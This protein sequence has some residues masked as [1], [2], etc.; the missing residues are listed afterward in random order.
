[1]KSKIL[2]FTHAGS[3]FIFMKAILNLYRKFYAV[4]KEVP[5]RAIVSQLLVLTVFFLHLDLRVP[6][7]HIFGEKV[8]SPFSVS[9]YLRI[10]GMLK[11]YYQI[12]Q[13][14]PHSTLAEIKQAFRRLALHIS[15]G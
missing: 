8:N 9:C 4:P 2:H 1:M 10:L 6:S 7:D 14:E 12:L 5:D 3:I 15:P 11:D 13:I